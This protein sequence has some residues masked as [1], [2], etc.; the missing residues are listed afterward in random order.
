M[1]DNPKKDKLLEEAQK[2]IMRG[3]FDKAAK[4]YEQ[5]LALEPSSI[6]LRQKLAEILIKAGRSED[7]RKEYETIGKH[8][9]NNGFYQKS[10]AVYKQLQKFFPDDITLSFTLAGLNEK[11]GL[12]ANALSEYKQVYDYYEKAGNASESIKILNIMQTVD[13]QNITVKIKLAEA[14]F[15]Q[16]N[17]EDAYVLFAKTAS[18]LQDRGDSEGV[19]KLNN[20]VQQLFENKSDFM[21]E[22]LA[23]QVRSDNAAGAVS[24]LQ[25]LLRSNSN[26]KRV[27]DLIIEAYRRLGQSQ[28]V[29]IAF[30][31]YHKLLPDEPAAMVGLMLCSVAERDV[32]T[33]ME[34]LDLYENKLLA[35]GQFCDLE[36]IYRALDEID[37]INVKVLEGLIKVVK[38]A[39]NESEVVV[40]SDKLRSLS[41]ISGDNQ[42]ESEVKEP[43]SGLFESLDFC[44]EIGVGS[45]FSSSGIQPEKVDVS[46]FA[47]SESQVSETQ[48]AGTE[49]E[50]LELDDLAS[51]AEY[52]IE[53]DLD[54]DNEAD[55]ELPT[56]TVVGD[57]LDNN[58][59]LD[60]VGDLFDS[61]TTAPS[62]VK[63]GSE[64]DSSDA[65]SHFDLGLAFKEMGLYDEAINEFRKAA[66]DS[67][68]R[69]VCLILQG[70][71][72]R[73]R[74][75]FDTAINMLNTLLKPSLSLDDSCAVKYELVLTYE[76]AGKADEAN[77]LLNEID[78]ANPDFRDVS[79]RLNAAHPGNSLDFSDDDLE[80]F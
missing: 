56:E 66:S 73:E 3:Q 62:G 22:V 64:M 75:E 71:C 26:D 27:W 19:S 4:A 74:G 49:T 16:G 14:Y 2:L 76:S 12:I 15:Q 29:K 24:G 52:D 21:L 57:V 1:A 55:L 54:I 7:A 36:K 45:P 37:P 8:F 70:A 59:W 38:A 41:R 10:I 30:Q 28:R 53:I 47:D 33:T 61:I 35:I 72:L 23:G 67:T 39:G 58:D 63:Y 80:I 6:N 40:L 13:P 46:D 68:R 25:G 60:S 44:S 9:A 43:E 65:Q 32:K 5:V 48:L 42:T 34:L 69:M 77:L 17:K 11:H 31:H 20:R 50:S 78:S 79:S 51:L 18:L